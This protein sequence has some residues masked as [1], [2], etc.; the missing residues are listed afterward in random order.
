MIYVWIVF[1]ILFA[2]LV[3]E[4]GHVIAMRK[5]GVWV[6]ELGIGL[7][8]GKSIGWTF[9]SKKYPG[10]TFRLSL[11]PA[12][13]GAFV[14]PEKG[15]ENFERL[16]YRDQAFI[17][18]GGVMGN[19]V[20]ITG[21]IALMG[22]LVPAGHVLTV[23]FEPFG[24]LRI[25]GEYLW[26]GILATGILLRFARSITRFLFP[27][28]AGAIL[29]FYIKVL[30]TL[31][32]GTFVE[33]SG[34]VFTIAQMGSTLPLKLPAMIYFAAFVSYLLA[35]TNLLPFYPLDGALPIKTLGEKYLPKKVCA[36]FLNVGFVCLLVLLV[37]STAGDF[38]R[39]IELFH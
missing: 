9:R 39:I 28:G 29:V 26:Y 27:L 10:K 18:G 14:K 34:G 35:L 6:N 36:A 23:A 33:R 15:W 19:L 7:P 5:C 22:L 38:R 8:F 2:I 30:S 32:F 20:L 31:S 24:R 16:S 11:Y 3:H 12:L 1:I 13:V 37:F 4:I 21:A 17:Y 25:T